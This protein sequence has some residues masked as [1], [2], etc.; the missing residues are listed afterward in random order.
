MTGRHVPPTAQIPGLTTEPSTE[1]TPAQQPQQRDRRAELFEYLPRTL[2]VTN[3]ILL[4]L[5][6]FQ[7]LHRPKYEYMT[8]S[9]G[10]LTF[11]EEMNAMGRKGWKTESCRRASDSSY[12]SDYSY[13]CIMS[14]PKLGW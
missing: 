12:S 6:A 4:V 7:V 8:A 1:S 14:R 5:L 3:A 13:E 2:M 9:P 10:D 11:T